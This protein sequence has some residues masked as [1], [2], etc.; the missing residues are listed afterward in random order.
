MSLALLGCGRS[1]PVAV[2][3][4]QNVAG[5]LCDFDVEARCFVD[6]GGLVPCVDQDLVARWEPT[7]GSL[8]TI[9]T[10]VTSARKPTY[11]NAIFSG[12]DALEF[13]TDDYLSLS[14]LPAT[15]SGS[16]VPFSVVA[17]LRINSLTGQDFLSFSSSA[18]SL[19]VIGGGATSYFVARTDSANLAKN[20]TG[21]TSQYNVSTQGHVL[22]FVFDGTTA[23]MWIDGTQVMNNLDLNVATLTLT[24]GTIGARVVA[25]VES[26]YA[27][28]HL[29]RLLI[30]S[31]ALSTTDRTNL[32]AA[33]KTKYGTP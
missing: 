26:R 17:V 28:M 29:G 14:L 33:L 3:G 32:Q 4:V 19:M 13:V 24:T 21:G 23:N 16:D 25:G 6:S 15:L 1:N 12:Y 20:A 9:A 18:S 7:A 31:G 8:A 5:L 10:Q 22:A 2:G 30:Y 11:R 27:E